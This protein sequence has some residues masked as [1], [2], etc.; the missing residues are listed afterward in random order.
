MV[1]SSHLSLIFKQLSKRNV[2]AV[3]VHTQERKID[4]KRVWQI[5]A[6]VDCGV[7]ILFTAILFQLLFVNLK[8]FMVKTLEGKNNLL[9]EQHKKHD[10][11]KNCDNCVPFV[12]SENPK[13]LSC[14]LL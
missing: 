8:L 9:Q 2:H 7:Y 14:I 6:I 5:L 11:T 13:T 4:L 12:I 3:C 10:T 1:K